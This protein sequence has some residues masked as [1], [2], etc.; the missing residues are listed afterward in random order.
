MQDHSSAAVY[1]LASIAYVE[2]VCRTDDYRCIWGV[3]DCI[4]TV[5]FSLHPTSITMQAILKCKNYSVKFYSMS[6]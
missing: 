2:R 4:D 3:D 1:A 6:S 5:E